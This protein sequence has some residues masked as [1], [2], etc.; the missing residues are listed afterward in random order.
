[1]SN[2]FLAYSDNPAHYRAALIE[3]IENTAQVGRE[4]LSELREINGTLDGVLSEM[5]AIRRTQAEGL[6]LQQAM[7][8]REVFQD[9]MEEFVFQFDKLIGQCER[10]D[11]DF[12]PTTQFYLLDG[13]LKQIDAAGITTAVVKGR[14]N[15]AAFD[16]CVARGKTLFKQLVKHPEVQQA[17]AWAEGEQKKRLAGDQKRASAEQQ[18]RDDIKELQRQIER[19][20]DSRVRFTYME[21]L[22]YKFESLPPP[23]RV[24]VGVLWVAL[25]YPLFM[26]VGP[27]DERAANTATD[28]EIERLQRRLTELQT[29]G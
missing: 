9:R 4:Q 29:G 28:E 19:L 17:I 7:L 20:K 3:S 6:A 8:A 27:A 26:F 22:N 13:M 16:A 10:T 24:V 5:A 12:P 25:L 21:W 2:R 18:R 14:D 1:M 11:S 15:K 23:V